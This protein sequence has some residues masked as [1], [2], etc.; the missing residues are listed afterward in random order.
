M[1]RALL[2]MLLVAAA[3]V[4]AGCGNVDLRGEAMTAAETSAL[5]AWQAA[6]RAGADSTTPTW[7]QGYLL[8]D[9]AQWRY[10]VRAAKKDPT[11]GPKLAIEIQNEAAA[12][13]PAKGGN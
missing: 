8:E 1:K 5:D 11:W 4:I 12:T 2:V 7:E 6:Q 10:F 13:Q 3:G 9:Y